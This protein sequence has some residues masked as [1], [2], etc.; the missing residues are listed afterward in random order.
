MEDNKEKKND[1][2]GTNNGFY[3]KRHSLASKNQISMSQKMRY[4]QYKDAVNGIKHVTMN[5][6]LGCDEFRQRLGQIIRE[7]ISKLL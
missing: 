4:Q 7:E 3:G 6:L 1:R 5:D 2:S